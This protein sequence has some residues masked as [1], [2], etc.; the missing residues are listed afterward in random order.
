MLHVS[1]KCAWALHQHIEIWCRAHANEQH[2]VKKNTP[3]RSHI[4][5]CCQ[6]A[7]PPRESASV[8]PFDSTRSQLVFGCVICTQAQ[9][10][11]T[12]RAVIESHSI[13][14]I[15]ERR[16]FI[17]R[18]LTTGSGFPRWF[19]AASLPHRAAAA[20]T[21]LSGV[22]P[23]KDNRKRDCLCQRAVVW[24]FPSSEWGDLGRY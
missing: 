3:S 6:L 22:S 14:R 23:R 16:L 13:P 20:F 12:G 5:S 7:R 10:D 9:M 4:T 18:H 1:T 2:V 8:F 19:A 24:N 21:E 11:L 15:I 17:Q